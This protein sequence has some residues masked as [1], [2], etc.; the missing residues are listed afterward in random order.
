MN[1]HDSEQIAELMKDQGYRVTDDEKRADLVIVNTCSIRA[2]AEQKAYSTLGRFRRMKEDNPSMI[3]GVGGCLAQQLGTKFFKKL[4]YLDLVFGTHN[5]HRLPE[6]VR[7]VERTGDRVSET[8]FHETVPSL[9]IV[10]PPSNGNI[11]SFVTIMQGCNNFCAFCVVPYLRGR[12]E[13]RLPDAIIEEIRC[14]TDN[15]IREVTLLGQNVNS[16]GKTLPDDVDFSQ[17][18]RKIA[19]ID[20]VRRIRFTTSHPKDLSESLVACFADIDKL[21]KHIH[22]P[23]QSGS[24]NILKKMNRHYTVD[25]Y[26]DKVDKLRK[27]CPEISLSTDIIVGFPGETEK[28]FQKTIDLME[29]VRFDSSF[30]FK[31]SRRLGTAAAGF[32]NHVPED[33]KAKRLSILQSLQ[34]RHMIASNQAC[35]GTVEHV[36]VEGYSKNS[37]ADI[38]GRTGSNK[39]VNFTGDIEKVGTIVPVKIQKAYT[40]SLRGEL[41]TRKGDE[42]C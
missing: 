9:G 29:K 30:S 35:V 7:T 4:P 36:L 27:A 39:I 14:L 25:D 28:D 3:I 26:L 1:V 17:L 15:D 22:L 10:T 24:D 18:L 40:H 19:D 37:Q 23:V 33:A 34:E 38:M 21:C 5:I 2:K 31:Y 16:Y 20:G 11:C 41:L 8:T 6:L 42:R 12:E 32:D 13:S